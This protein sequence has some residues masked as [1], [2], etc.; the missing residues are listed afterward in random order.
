MRRYRH[1][2]RQ[3]HLH[4]AGNGVDKGQ[5][6]TVVRNVSSLFT[7]AH[8]IQKLHGDE[9]R[10]TA[11]IACAGVDGAGFGFGQCDELLDRVRGQAGRCRHQIGFAIHQRDRSEIPF[12]VD[13]HVLHQRGAE[14]EAGHRQQQRVAIGV[15]AADQL[16]GGHAAHAGAAAVIH[17]QALADAVAHFLR[18][19]A[20][21]C[22]SRAA[23]Y[24][25]DDNAYGF[26]GELRVYLCVD[27]AHNK[28]QTKP[29]GIN[30]IT[31][32]I[33]AADSITASCVQRARNT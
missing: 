9:V 31:Q 21:H 11:K 14:G 29:A 26:G 8:R 16:Q 3:R 18:I 25:R 33:H 2:A 22:V 32:A 28:G 4:A 15:G 24:L 20:H 23:G 19:H 12:N 30:E 27:C 6:H 17:D 13:G 1:D 7:H 10:A 5:A